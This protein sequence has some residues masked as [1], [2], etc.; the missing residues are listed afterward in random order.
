MI[1]APSR[2][3]AFE[4]LDQSESD[5]ESVVS[6]VQSS[7]ITLKNDP[8]RIRNEFQNNDFQPEEL[9]ELAKKLEISDQTKKQPVYE[10]MGTVSQIFDSIYTFFN[11]L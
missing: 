3:K 11:A 8:N 6:D 4:N 1:K 5:N 9:V 2:K 10:A 7:I